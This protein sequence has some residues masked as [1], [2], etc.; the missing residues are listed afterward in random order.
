MSTAMAVKADPAH[1]FRLDGK[2]C[3]VTGASSGIGLRMAHTLD[4]A[5]ATVVLAARRLDRLDAATST[6]QRARAVQCDLTVDADLDRLMNVAFEVGGPDVLVNNAGAVGRHTA[7]S[8]SAGEFRGGL[9][10]NLVAPFR[11]A[12]LAAA[13]M[14][15]KGSGSII[16][17]VS[18]LGL[19]GGGDFGTEP[20]YSASKGAMVSLTRELAAQWA[21]Q[22][23]RVNAIA[24]GWFRTEM[25]EDLFADDRA[26]GWIERKTPMRRLGD[27]AE[28]DGALLFLASEASTFVTGQ[29]LAVDGGWTAI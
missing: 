21:R 26:R 27:V 24:P 16:N 3:V 4:A 12:Q 8:Q 10:V 25:T 14:K 29:V 15:E 5:G 20:S 28:L 19:V 13:S 6:M 7:D 22:G 18:I 23:T 11:L 2:V 9:D 1:L 17:V